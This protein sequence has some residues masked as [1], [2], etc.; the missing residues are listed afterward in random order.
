MKKILQISKYYYPFMGGTEQVARDIVGALNEEEFEHKIICF[1]ADA[2][3]GNY[4]CS[5]KDTVH[6]TVDDVEVIR[7]GCMAKLASQS[8]SLTYKNELKKIIEDFKPDV[9]MFHHPNPFVAS[10]MLPLLPSDIKF[11]LYWHL[12]ITKQKVLSKLFHLQM[13]KM[14]KR[15]DI[16][17]ATSP[18]YIEGSPYLQNFKEKCIVIP[19]AISDDRVAVTPSI[20]ATAQK[21]REKYKGKCIGLAVGRHVEY[22][23]FTYL[24]KSAKLLDENFKILIA[25]TG[26][27]TDSLKAEAHGCDNIEFLGR[28]SDDDLVAYYLACDILCFSSITKNEAFGIALAEGMYFEKPAVTFTIDGSGVNYVSLHDN[29]GLEVANRDVTAYADALRRLAQNPDLRN[30]YGIN[31]KKRVAENFMP[32][33]FIDNMHKLMKQL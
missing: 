4:T 24:I 19:N 32:S 2:K 21:I 26:P 17:I 5:S 33:H 3:D 28:V 11:V 6:D 23:G 31:A 13:V 27:L 18:N 25:G 30:S 22:K 20:E 9:V 16:V 14:L 29:T 7:C 15:A 8:L 10:I 12:D 1:N